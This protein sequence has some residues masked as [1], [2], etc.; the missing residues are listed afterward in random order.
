MIRDI[1]IGQFFPGNSMIHK[2][3]PRAKILLTLLFI[4]ALFICKN[5]FSTHSMNMSMNIFI[6]HVHVLFVVRVSYIGIL[7]TI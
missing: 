6:C 7:R 5:F 4:I 1:T 3:D 2:L